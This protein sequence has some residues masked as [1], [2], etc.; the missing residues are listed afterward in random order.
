[1]KFMIHSC[2]QRQWYVD[3]FLVPSMI[4]QGIPKEDIYVY[5]DV[6]EDGNLKSYIQSSHLA[7]KMWG[8][9]VNVWHLQD[10]VILSR[11]FKKKV[12]EL[13]DNGLIIVCAFTCKYDDGREPGLKP[14]INHMWYSFPCMRVTTNISKEFATWADT[15]LWRDNQFGFWTRHKKG[16]D[17]IF[18]IFIESYHPNEPVLNLVPNIIDHIDYIVGGTVVN[19]NRERRGFDVRSHYWDEED[20]PLV[21]ALERK[22]LERNLKKK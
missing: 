20:E 13:E 8:A 12:D 9:D 6:N 2:N 19:P 4:E 1:M 7:Y 21:K 5:Q 16:D 17:H 15:Y 3:E 14:A 10:D 11:N 22:V 18:R